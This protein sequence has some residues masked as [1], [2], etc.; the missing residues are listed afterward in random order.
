MPG[1]QVFASFVYNIICTSSQAVIPQR[2][3]YET[4]TC[5]K[6]NTKQAGSGG[7]QQLRD[8]PGWPRY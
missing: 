7:A 6:W 4:M 3:R 2:Q 1:R 8:E 5:R